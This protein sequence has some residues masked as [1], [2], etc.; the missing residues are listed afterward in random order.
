[1]DERKSETRPDRKPTRLD[2]A[3][4][5]IE[6]YAADLRKMIKKLRQKMN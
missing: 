3:L 1:M 2:E 5:I 4:R 6:E